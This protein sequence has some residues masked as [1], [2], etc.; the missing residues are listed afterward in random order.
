MACFHPLVAWQGVKPDGTK[1][2]IQFEFKFG[3]NIKG[4]KRLLIPCGNCVGCRLEKSRQWAMRMVFESQMHE[5]NCFLTLTYDDEHL[6]KGETLVKKDV[7]MF[8]RMFRQWL[9]RHKPD[10]KIRYFACGEYGD[11]GNRPHYHLIIFGYKFE[12]MEKEINTESCCSVFTSKLLSQLWTKGFSSCGELSFESAAYV[13]R[14]CMK[15]ING[16]MAEEHYQ[17]RVPE[18]SVMSRRPGIG[19]A[20]FNKY[21]KGVYPKDSVVARGVRCLPPKYFDRVLKESNPELYEEIK[22]QRLMHIDTPED[23]DAYFRELEYKEEVFKE[24]AKKQLKR[25]L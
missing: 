19:Q 18:F 8:I 16:K 15:K 2:R 3:F 7:Q 5:D 6:P 24:N 1:T 11:R 20:W 13:A 14:Y 4:I 9:R 12:D 21:G 10:V 17:G 25:K 22:N 23:L